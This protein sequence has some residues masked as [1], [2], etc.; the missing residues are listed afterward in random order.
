[1][2]SEYH[3]GDMDIH[4]QK[5]TYE[6]F[7][8]LTKWGCLIIAVAITM[9]TLWFCTDAGFFGGLVP[10]LILLVLGLVFLRSKPAA[11]H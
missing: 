4:E 7:G 5:A 1:M 11:D 8:T 2:A 6:A 9:A 10:G 3:H